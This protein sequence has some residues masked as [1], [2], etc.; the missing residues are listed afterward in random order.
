MALFD[1][2][3]EG[4]GAKGAAFAGALAVLFEQGHRVRR[5]VGT[6]AGAI[7]AALLAAGYAPEELL[8]AVSEQQ[9]GKPRFAAF[10]DRPR[11]SDFTASELE[12]SEMVKALPLGGRALLKL[13]LRSPLYAQ[14]FCFTECGG[15][16]A[17]ADF[18]TWLAE[19]LGAKGVD[20]TTT[21]GALYAARSV[22]LTVVVSDTTGGEMLTLNHRT[23]PGVPVGWAVRMSMSIP[24]VWKEVV[25]REEWGGYEGRAKTGNIMVDGG[26]LSNFPI[27]LIADAEPGEALSLGLLLDET[28]AVPGAPPGGQRL[29]NVHTVRRVTRLMDTMMRA[30]DNAEVRCHAA[31]VCRLPVRGYSALEFDMSGDRRNALVDAGRAAMREHLQVRGLAPS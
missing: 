31:E 8:A 26:C 16:F 10:M 11:A 15:L 29:D 23:A 13:L 19:K 17:G 20:A 7:T 4:G 9:N 21:L 22:D 1:V 24:F 18:M 30:A 12:A 27:R 25:W 28:L 2:V 6:S 5:L 14:L 3:F